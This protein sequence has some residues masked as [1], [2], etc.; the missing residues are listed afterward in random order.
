MHGETPDSLLLRGGFP[1]AMSLTA[2]ESSAEQA[3]PWEKVPLEGA[4]C[5]GPPSPD[6]GQRLQYAY[7]LNAVEEPEGILFMLS[8]G[9]ACLKEGDPPPGA[10]G[11]AAQLYCKSYTN[12]QDPVMNDL[13]FGSAAPALALPYV[14][15]NDQANPFRNFVFVAV[16]YCTGDVHAGNMTEPY[17]YD[18]DPDAEFMVLH[19]GH[20]NVQAVVDDVY[21]RYSQDL[22]VVLTGFSAGGFGSIYNFPIVVEKWPRTTL[23]PDAGFAPPHPGSLLALQG[24]RIAER[25]GARALMPDYC[26]EGDC[27]ADTMSLLAAHAKAHDGSGDRPWRPFGYLQGQQDSVLSSYLEITKCGY[28]VSLM[29]GMT[30]FG[31]NVRGFVPAT[32]KHV[33]GVVNPLE[34]AYRSVRGVDPFEWVYQLA[35]AEGPE[36]LPPDAIDGWLPCNALFTPLLSPLPGPAR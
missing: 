3:S 9:G 1:D 24:E 21:A 14:R 29:Q 4:T 17:D 6:T 30:R 18:P 32:D 7:Y 28:E 11:I 8:G 13:L 31:D 25:W 33:F 27:L 2:A 23:I 20:L 10:S 12:F 22:P 5:G 36:E 26:A 16:P 19:R 35:R 15:R 34:Q